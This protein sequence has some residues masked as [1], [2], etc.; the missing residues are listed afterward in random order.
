MIRL[1]NVCLIVVLVLVSVSTSFGMIVFDD[2]HEHIFDSVVNEAISIEHND[3]W[4]KVTSVIAQGNAILNGQVIAY[5]DSY[6][7]A[8]DNAQIVGGYVGKEYSTSN[9]Y[10]GELTFRLES[11]AKLDLWGGTVVQNVTLANSAD[12]TVHNGTV[13]GHIYP[14]D[15]TNLEI[16]DGIFNGYV[17]SSWYGEVSIRGGVFNDE[18]IA[19]MQST[20]T[21][22]GSNFEVD[23]WEAPYGVYD[24]THR[25]GVLTGTLANGDLINTTIEIRDDAHIILAPVLEPCSLCFLAFGGLFLRRKVTG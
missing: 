9:I 15:S 7:E 12:L 24:S 17:L 22:Y 23:G 20:I 5:G 14:Y 10:G 2:G 4:D 25:E 3:F 19:N 1:G 6:F 13:N 18:I 16:F 8:R 11:H 21:I